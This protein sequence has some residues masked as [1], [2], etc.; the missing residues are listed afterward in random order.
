M[1]D[2]WLSPTFWQVAVI[3]AAAGALHASFQLGVS[4]LTSLSTHSFGAKRSTNHMLGLGGSYILGTFSGVLL[5]ELALTYLLGLVAEP[6]SMLWAILCG[7]GAGV[8]VAVLLFYYRAGRGTMLWLPR[9]AAEY[10]QQR[11]TLTKEAIEAFA[12]GLIT[13]V[14]ELPFIAVPILIIAM[15]FRGHV[16]S[17][18]MLALVSYAVIATLPLVALICIIGSGKKLSAIQR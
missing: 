17:N 16:T 3:V 6:A 2:F 9:S 18:S 4:V 5:L 13:V 10:L 15:L 1:T 12:L 7:I 8:G 14:A 11:I